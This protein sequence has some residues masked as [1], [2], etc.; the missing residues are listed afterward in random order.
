MIALAKS[1]SGGGSLL[2]YIMSDKKGYELF[3]SN[4]CGRN[5]KEIMEEIKI[6]Q[7]FN[8]RAVN[9]TLSLVLSPSIND[10]NKLSD[11]DL[12]EISIEFLKE[13][14]IDINQFQILAFIHT[15]KQHKH[16]HFY[17]NRL[18]MNTLK[19]V[20]DHHIGKRAQWIAHRMAL[21][22]NLISAKQVM[23]NKI[24]SI[25]KKEVSDEKLIKTDIYKKHLKAIDKHL[26]SFSEY[27]DVMKSMG[28]IVQPT[29]NKQGL[30]QGH[31]LIDVATNSNYKASEVNRKMNL[32][33]IGNN[34]SKKEKIM[35]KTMKYGR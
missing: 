11:S 9:K 16:L 20:N 15:E 4:L 5:P 26:S 14:N 31:R 13:L 10:G 27:I 2:N 34:N 28:V 35:I 21:K 30:T 22:R 25:E 18:N 19:L 24:K 23:I 33:D 1:C 7:D 6:I 3:R 8:Q 12:R 17:I 32:N 29:I